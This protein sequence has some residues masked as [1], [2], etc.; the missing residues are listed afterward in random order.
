M[1]PVLDSNFLLLWAFN[2]VKC[3]GS[4][5]HIPPLVCRLPCKHRRSMG[6]CG[7]LNPASPNSP[8][9]LA[10]PAAAAAAASLGP[11]LMLLLLLLLLLLLSFFPQNPTPAAPAFILPS[12]PPT[13]APV[14]PKK[15]VAEEQ[16]AVSAEEEAE[17]QAIRIKFN[18][19]VATPQEISKYMQYVQRLEKK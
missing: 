10:T 4:H 16:P 5:I 12:M 18:D 19:N 8:L 7:R 14:I 9:S 6:N 3:R 1:M 13:A 17:M 2:D 15:Q 11:P